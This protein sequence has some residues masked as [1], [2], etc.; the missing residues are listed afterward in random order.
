MGIFPLSETNVTQLKPQTE[1]AI[2]LLIYSCTLFSFLSLFY[3]LLHSQ[4]FK[5]NRTH[6]LPPMIDNRVSSVPCAHPD[7]FFDN[8]RPPSNRVRLAEVILRTNE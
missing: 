2:N 5:A 7:Q 1:M 4:L 6:S 8:H 3:R